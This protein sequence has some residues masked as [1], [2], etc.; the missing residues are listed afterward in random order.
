MSVVRLEQVGSQNRQGQGVWIS[1]A[2]TQRQADSRA[3][4]VQ[5][6]ST[7]AGAGTQR[8]AL[9]CRRGRRPKEGW[10]VCRRG[11]CREKGSWASREAPSG[12]GCT[13]LNKKGPVNE[14]VVVD[15]IKWYKSSLY[16]DF[17]IG[18]FIHNV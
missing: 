7:T 5:L 4:T 10:E 12:L 9:L 15:S 1:G 11:D 18:T 2:G 14:H 3:S 17:I 8:C 16:M 6:S 13:A